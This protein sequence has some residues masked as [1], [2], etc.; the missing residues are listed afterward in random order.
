MA[1]MT[2]REAIRIEREN[3]RRFVY[4]V[5]DTFTFP[6]LPNELVPTDRILQ[7]MAAFGT[8][9]PS[10]NPD[11]YRESRPPPLDP[12]TQM[13][14]GD[15]L[16]SCAPGT[17]AVIRDWYFTRKSITQ[18]AKARHL[19]RRQLGREWRAHLQVVRFKFLASP[20]LDLVKLAR[21]VP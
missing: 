3:I 10:E 18:I 20:H 6:G 14:A 8:G 17:K 7:R 5:C 19:S 2:A 16:Q 11:V 1:G 12:A 13:A 9:V 4:A 21:F 15:A